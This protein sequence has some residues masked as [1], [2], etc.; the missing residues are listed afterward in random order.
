M[1]LMIS[2][3]NHQPHETDAHLP[4]HFEKIQ[5]KMKNSR[6][7]FSPFTLYILLHHSQ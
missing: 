3:L 1:R 7:A 6:L 5:A 4:F 2:T